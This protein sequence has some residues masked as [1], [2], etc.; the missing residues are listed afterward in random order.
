MRSPAPAHSWSWS[1]PTRAFIDDPELFV[2]R[3]VV[4]KPSAGDTMMAT[5]EVSGRWPETGIKRVEIRVPDADAANVPV[6]DVT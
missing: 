5:K 1:Q 2:L 3:L 4:E 6:R